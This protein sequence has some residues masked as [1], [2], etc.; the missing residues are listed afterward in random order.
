M[1][2]SIRRIP[3][4]LFFAIAALALSSMVAPSRA[5]QS[6]TQ[7]PAVLRFAEKVNHDSAVPTTK[8]VARRR[9]SKA[10]RIPSEVVLGKQPSIR[11]VAGEE[12]ARL[13][14]S[15]QTSQSVKRLPPARPEAPKSTTPTTKQ[16]VAPEIEF[17]NTAGSETTWA[18]PSD[19][20]SAP[21]KIEAFRPAKIDNRPTRNAEASQVSWAGDDVGVRPA[22]WRKQTRLAQANDPLSALEEAAESAIRRSPKSVAPSPP[23]LK[24]TPRRPTATK[25]LSDR[26]RLSLDFLPEDDDSSPLDALER[27]TREDDKA[28]DEYP[29]EEVPVVATPPKKRRMPYAYTLSDILEDEDDT[30]APCIEQAYCRAMWECAGGKCLSP[31]DR[32]RRDLNRNRVLR[33][34]SCNPEFQYRAQGPNFNRNA[35]TGNGYGSVMK[36]QLENQ[37]GPARSSDDAQFAGG[38]TRPADVVIETVDFLQEIP[39]KGAR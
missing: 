18:I 9:I 36:Y 17:D 27:I 10:S 1:F 30:E 35:Y 19:T 5:Q 24:P 38:G 33:N 13:P 3:C 29:Y 11:L 34:G 26:R 37:G 23:A 14:Q 12:P 28:D 4:S 15:L 6:Q 22:Y 21:R 16:P 2:R 25:P 7:P 32:W 31:L 8:R 20:E 39:K